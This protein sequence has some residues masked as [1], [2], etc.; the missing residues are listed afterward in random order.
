MIARYC[1]SRTGVLSFLIVLSS[2]LVAQDENT[3]DTKQNDPPLSWTDREFWQTPSGGPVSEGWRFADGEVSLVDPKKAGNIVTGPLPSHF[4][5]SWKWKI[6][7]GVNS[8]LKYRVR[9]FGKQLGNNSYLG[10]EYQIIDSKA[11]STSKGSTAA[12]Y[13]LVE[14]TKEKTLHPPGE[15]NHSKIVAVGSKIEH[16]L[17]DELVAAASIDGPAWET[18]IALSKFHGGVDFGRPQMGDRFMLTDHGGKVS[19]KDF[20]FVPHEAP[21]VV[22]PPRSGPFLANGT[23]NGW[24][25]QNSIVIWTRT[26]RNPEMAV[27]G[28]AFI[29]IS[30]KQ[31]A[32]LA[33]Q[34]DSR[35]LLN[36]QLPDGA[37]LD[38]ML[39]ACPGA[40]GKVRLSYYYGSQRNKMKQTDWFTTSA[41]DDFIAQW[42]L[43]DL[44]PN[45]R[46]VT[47]VEAQT[48]D[49][50]PSA[51]ACGSFQTAPATDD[52]ESLKFCITTCHDFIRRDDGMNGHK[53][54]PAM[55]KLSPSFI[56]HAGDI[57]YY[58]KPDPWAMTKSLM[59]FKWGRIF[60]LP[61]NRDFYSR[62]TT[63][64]IKDD[65]DTLANDCWPGQRYGAVTFEEGV[66]LFNEEQF[67]S[68]DPR[69]KNIRW[70]RD[71]EIWVLEGRDY[72]SP[73]SMPDG[74]EK[75]ILGKQQKEWLFETLRK[76]DAKFKLICSPTPIVGPDR[77]NKKDN[78][79]NAIF[80]FEGDEIRD[81]ISK[82]PGVIVTCG[83]RHW[84]YAS[85]DETTNLWEFGCGPGSEK[86]ELGWKAGDERPTHR[87]LRVKGGFLS[88][89]LKSRKSEDD[90][91]LVIRH[92]T[93][94]GEEVSRFEFPN[95]QSEPETQAESTKP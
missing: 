49:G 4:E 16:Y 63:Y 22:A 41:D 13:D 73:N 48:L 11:D 50:E 27:D 43:N 62:T 61:N 8:G 87:F 60:S 54:Y 37:T 93:V 21:E 35:V 89:E 69:Y 70:G 75:T 10:L 85:V 56:V 20:E 17:N 40:S 80:A 74:P 30:N 12:I 5:L 45:A 68:R 33:K 65:H 15:W 58:D 82:I 76:S 29:S 91:V 95:E 46:Y 78:H 92:H 7:K 44:K 84:Q 28:K 83:D 9:K 6:E 72:R 90:S 88:G 26:T 19:Y 42:R 38:D 66:R 51:V 1:L 52:A 34:T 23:R 32:E 2:C 47:I 81:V 14:P 55:S 79:A 86:H 64:F 24:A 67:P 57:E 94:T 36:A 18:M 39:G 25:D 59:R 3:P 31:A 53:I 71:L 77:A